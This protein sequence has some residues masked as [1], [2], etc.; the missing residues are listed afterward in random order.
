MIGHYSFQW[1]RSKHGSKKK[2]TTIW[3]MC[4]IEIE[5]K[6]QNN[7]NNFNS[8]LL[9]DKIP[10]EY[11]N[12]SKI[13][14]SDYLSIIS[15]SKLQPDYI[16]T[17]DAKKSF[18]DKQLKIFDFVTYSKINQNISKRKELRGRVCTTLQVPDLKKIRTNL[19]KE[20][21]KL[22][23]V[24]LTNNSIK[25]PRPHI[26][27]QIEFLLRLLNVKTKLKWFFK[28]YFIDNENNM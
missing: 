27:F 14:Q 10:V 15:K 19:L 9:W 13:S 24:N 20:V 3:G 5:S 8:S 26:C 7:I 28:G 11:I 6:L 16:A 17:L 22:L 23:N 18:Y 12:D 2:T 21:E 25:I 4:D 1:G